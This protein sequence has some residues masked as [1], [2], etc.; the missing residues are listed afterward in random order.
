MNEALEE[1]EECPDEGEMLV[2]RRALSGIASPE[3][4][5]E[6]ENIFHTRCIE[7]GNRCVLSLL[8]GEGVPMWPPR[9]WWR[10]SKLTV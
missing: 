10:S 4:L 7:N 2:I 8:M 1:V 3:D 9:P 5:E 6:R